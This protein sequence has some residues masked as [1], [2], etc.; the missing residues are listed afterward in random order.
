LQL[1]SCTQPLHITK[2]PSQNN[3]NQ[4]TK[5]AKLFTIASCKHH[6]TAAVSTFAHDGDSVKTNAHID[7]GVCMLM[8]DD[9]IAL[10]CMV[11]HTWLSH[12]STLSKCLT[13]NSTACA[14]RAVPLPF[15]VLTVQATCK[16]FAVGR[17][18]TAL[19]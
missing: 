5:A 6:A 17:C 13:A 14:S 2:V 10:H 12:P 1:H 8:H 15:L 18:T 3:P 16:S 9:N 4:P 11:M 19:S 7:A